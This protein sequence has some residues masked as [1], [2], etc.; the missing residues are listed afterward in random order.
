MM[1]VASL[2]ASVV[3]ASAGDPSTGWLSYARFDADSSSHKIT[4]ISMSWIVPENPSRTGAS[5]ALWFGTQT[6]K[7]DGALIQPI[8][9]WLSNGWYIFHEIYD[10]TNGHNEQPNHVKVQA[11]DHISAWVAFKSSDRS[12][13]MSITSK[14]L[15]KTYTHNY[16]LRSAQKTVESTAYIVI[17]HQ[18]S[19][20][21]QL[22]ADGHITFTNIEVE[23]EGTKLSSPKWTAL[24][25]RPACGS[26][27][28]VIDSHTVELQWNPSAT[29]SD[30]EWEAWK[31]EFG[32]VYNGDEDEFR[33]NVFEQNMAEAAKLQAENP[34]AEFGGTEFSDWTEAEFMGLLG[35]VPMNSTAP[36]TEVPDVEVAD[37]IDWTGTATTPV[38]NQ[39]SCGSCWAFSATE[40][41]ESDA[42]LQHG[43]NIELAPQELVDCTSSGSGSKRGGCN[44]GWPYKAYQVVKDVG[45]M[46]AESDYPYKAK[47][48]VCSISSSKMKVS[49][50]GYEEPGKQSE[51]KMKTYVGSTGPLSVCVDASGWKSYK[52]GVFTSGCGTK[53]NHCVQIVGYGDS[54]STSYWK[55]RNS[56][57][58]SFG[59]A[60]HIRIK[61]G[62]N[63]CGINSHPTKVNTQVL[64]PEVTV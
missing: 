24:Q 61:I 34:E 30:D 3:L 33:R 38:K 49:L 15:G 27:A 39:A 8:C 21:G 11:G 13:D 23:V 36:A 28:V 43:A 14:N 22:P 60:G 50:T 35:S 62:S 40:Q 44:G 17:E 10:W 64:L 9:K 59:E 53:I 42:M 19:S 52:S 2:L 47:N 16:K 32:R 5:P 37:S 48:G 63:L 6:F 20:C 1:R 18:P 58:T 25:E 54:G 46:E 12:Y 4:N 41:I 26:K 51:S 7:G 55:V 29:E 45:G 56:W 31:Q 57:K